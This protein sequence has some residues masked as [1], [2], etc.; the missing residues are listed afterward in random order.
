MMDAAKMSGEARTTA[1]EEEEGPTT[2]PPPLSLTLSGP[3]P[4]F[5]PPFSKKAV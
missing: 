2:P 3:A 4:W 5:D 1:E